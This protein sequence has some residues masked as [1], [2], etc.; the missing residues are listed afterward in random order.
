MSKFTN[1]LQV[2]LGKD[3]YPFVAPSGSVGTSTPANLVTAS[4]M[5]LPSC[6][7]VVR[8]WK[9]SANKRETL[10]FADV[11]KSPVE[12]LL[13]TY[14]LIARGYS[15]A[16]WSGPLFIFPALNLLQ[17]G[18]T[19]GLEFG[20]RTL[21]AMITKPLYDF[22]DYCN[23]KLNDLF[24]PDIIFDSPFRRG[25][26]SVA[27][28]VGKGLVITLLSPF[29]CIGQALSLAGDIFSSTR[30]LVDA[31][32]HICNPMWWGCKIYEKITKT[33]T[34][35]P[36]FGFVAKAFISS[37][38]KLL[39]AAGAVAAIVLTAG[40]ATPL[41]V[42]AN[43][44]IGI[45]GAGLFATFSKI[46]SSFVALKTTESLRERPEKNSESPKKTEK[47]R[48]L[49]IVKGGSTMT[50]TKCLA[51]KNAKEDI[52]LKTQNE[53]PKMSH[54]HVLSKNSFLHHEET[55]TEGS[56]KKPAD[57]TATTSHRH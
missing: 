34:E 29:W 56:A 5:Q 52:E 20:C 8:D 28:F 7:L 41:T 13:R 9:N 4:N 3:V 37:V 49:K 30:Q 18:V 47:G 48:R 12:E 51:C 39:P 31:A 16:E 2:A 26:K 14:M 32:L 11:E 36:S 6:E 38:F 55:T 43:T 57:V 1:A 54:D 21:A 25:M 27:N 53:A 42:A 44:A 33:S 23:E 17:I 19:M 15:Y 50:A 22:Y 45:F 46:C 35:T 40:L 10:P 24:E